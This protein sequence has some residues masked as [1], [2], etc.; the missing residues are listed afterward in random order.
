[1]LTEKDIKKYSPMD[2]SPNDITDYN[3]INE[4]KKIMKEAFDSDEQLRWGYIWLI[5]MH[6]YDEICKDGLKLDCNRRNEIA[7]KILKVIFY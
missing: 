2:L 3:K 7:E 6:L 5:A 4:A 1:M